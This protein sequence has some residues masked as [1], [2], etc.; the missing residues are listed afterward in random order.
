MPASRQPLRCGR[1]TAPSHSCLYYY[2]CLNAA[3][4]VGEVPRALNTS[5]VTPVHKRGDTA[6]PNNYRP[7]AVGEPII[8][9]YANMINRRQLSYTEETEPARTDTGWVSTTSLRLAPAFHLATPDH[10]RSP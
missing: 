9:L 10:A 1:E 3:F 4:R 6:E 2:W 8:R 7:I 5:H